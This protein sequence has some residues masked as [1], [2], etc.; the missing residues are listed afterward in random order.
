MYKRDLV[1]Q[2]GHHLFLFGARGTGK[3]TYL[4]YLFKSKNVLKVDLLDIEIEQRL[5]LNPKI[6]FEQIEADPK[7]THVIIDEIQK[8]PKLL[9]LI[10]QYIQKNKNKVIFVLTGSSAKKLKQ[11]GANLL[12]GRAFVN[13]MYPLTYSELGNDFDLTKYLEVGGLPEV[14]SFNDRKLENKYLKTYALTY[15]K[16][17]IWAEHLIK[18]L[19]PFRKFLELAAQANGEIINFSKLARQV[20]VDTKTIQSYFQIL[21]ETLVA[22]VVEAFSSSV[23]KRLIKS[24]RFY[25]FDTGVQRALSNTLSVPLVKSTFGYG[26]AFEHFI[27]TQIIT[28]I[29]YLENDFKYYYLKTEAGV[30]VDL[31]LESPSKELMLIEIK[32]SDQVDEYDIKHLEDISKDLK[33]CKSYVLSQDKLRRKINNTYCLFWA[34]G[35]D[36]ILK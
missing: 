36:E 5:A 4:D 1:L 19:E 34:D 20:G 6:L 13:Y 16:E 28:Q 14:Y 24:P 10:H 15:L 25:F 32:S 33:N 26:K 29:N 22:Y 11:G 2:V 35:I 3:T 9:D 31:V 21:E 27:I 23:R 7:I 8:L 17:E 12:A 18:K 30:E